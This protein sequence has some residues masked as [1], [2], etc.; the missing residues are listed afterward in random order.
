MPSPLVSP[1]WL[2]DKLGLQGS[3]TENGLIVVDGSW[4]LP[5]ENRDPHTEYQS[6]HIPGAVR[7]DIDA[8][9]DLGSG[10]PHTLPS[11]EQFSK[12]MGALGIA[13]TNTIVIYD[14]VGL[15][16]A[17]RVWWTFS[18]F[19]VENVYILD[20]G[21]PAWKALNLPLETGTTARQATIF[22]IK[23]PRTAVASV[24]DMRAYVNTGSAQIVDARSEARF[25]GDAPEP[26]PG[27]RAGHIP[28]SYSLPFSELLA[29]GHLKRAD[30]ITQAFISAGVDLS[31]PVVVSCG[32]GVT[33]AVLALGLTL[34][35]KPVAALY[36]GS[37]AEWG[38]RTDLPISTGPA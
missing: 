18:Y 12:T 10:L 28:G 20:G 25:R 16:S 9:S 4:H 23:S 35:D 2:A 24:E 13:D 30:E 34:I 36:D 32:S 1:Q 29:E 22:T 3:S 11:P 31:K 7:F 21:L 26:R 17:A 6:G 27:L 5:T 38:S 8:I 37:W 33:A 15:F 14:S 19:G